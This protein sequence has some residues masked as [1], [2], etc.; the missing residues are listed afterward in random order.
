VEASL[1]EW[2]QETEGLQRVIGGDWLA[3]DPG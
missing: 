2:R 1:W 3:A